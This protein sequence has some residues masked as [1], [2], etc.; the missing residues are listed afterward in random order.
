MG[1][2]NAGWAERS[3]YAAP[4]QLPSLPRAHP[5]HQH[6]VRAPHAGRDVLV[7]APSEVVEF[8]RNVDALIERRVWARRLKIA[9]DVT[10][11]VLMSALALGVL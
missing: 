2:E 3:E 9:T 6:R 4:V 1:E 5:V 11:A 10:L 8:R 7:L